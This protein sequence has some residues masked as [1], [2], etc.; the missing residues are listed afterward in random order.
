[1]QQDLGRTFGACLRAEGVAVTEV[2]AMLGH[3]DSRMAD[4]PFRSLAMMAKMAR[5]TLRN[6]CPGA[7]SNHR[8]GDFQSPALPTELP[9]P[10]AR[11]RVCMPRS[12]GP[13]KVEGRRRPPG[14]GTRSPP[15]GSARTGR[16]KMVEQPFVATSPATRRACLRLEFEACIRAPCSD[17]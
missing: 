16:T 17:V 12:D 7:E 2:T 11:G 10:K 5:V 4:R 14:T 15:H 9:G 8:H 13:V 3:A 6:W 1:M